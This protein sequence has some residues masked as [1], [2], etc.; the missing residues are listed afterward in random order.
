MENYSKEVFIQ[1]LPPSNLEE[2][3]FLL[4][5]ELAFAAGLAPKFDGFLNKK[6]NANFVENSS[7]QKN[8]KK[9]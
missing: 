2:K 7:S 9:L 1:G 5:V 6:S 3:M 4:L 8:Y